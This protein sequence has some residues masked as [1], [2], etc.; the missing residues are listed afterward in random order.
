M[1]V[2]DNKHTCKF[3]QD[4]IKDS[5]S[6]NNSNKRKRL[7]KAYPARVHLQGCMVQSSSSVIL[8]ACLRLTSQFTDNFLNNGVGIQFDNSKLDLSCKIVSCSRF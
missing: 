1:E 4:K 8:N 3:G 5:Y 2:I 6:V 7:N